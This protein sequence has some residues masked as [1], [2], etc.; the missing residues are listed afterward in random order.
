MNI[1]F[2]D[3]PETDSLQ[4]RS[5]IARLSTSISNKIISFVNSQ[6]IRKRHFL[7]LSLFGMGFNF[8]R[9]KVFVYSFLVLWATHGF[10][11]INIDTTYRISELESMLK[12]ARKSN[13]KED[14]AASYYLMAE[15]EANNFDQSGDAFKNYAN[16]REYYAILKD[17][18]MMSRIDKALGIKYL[19]SGYYQE[20]LL[21]FNKAMKYFIK[22]K[23]LKTIT[24]I[25]FHISQIY[26][27]KVDPENE[28]KY[29]NKAIQLNSKL[30][31]TT[32]LVEFM[33]HKIGSYVTLS[34]LDTAEIIAI[35]AVTLSGKFKN[36]ESMSRSLYHLG[37]INRIRK[38]YKRAIKYLNDSEE[39]VSVKPF[40]IY[41]RTLYNEMANCYQKNGNYK[42]AFRYS[43]KYSELND[44]ILNKDRIESQ[45]KFAMYYKADEKEGDNEKLK[46][47]KKSVEQKNEQQKTAMYVLT[48]G[49]IMLLALMYYIINFYRQK[50]KAE[51]II[52]GQKQEISHQKI[53]ELED[54][55]KISSMQSM[56]EGQE[57][58][59]ERISKDLHDSLGGLLS[60]IKLQFDSVKSKMNKV[61]KLKEYKSANSM[62]D[63]AVEEVRSISQNLQPGSLMKLGL[64]PALN[65]LFNR[66]DEDIYPEVDFQYYD[67]PEK[68]PTMVA[69]S[70]YRVIQ[71]LLHN[72]IKHAQ[73]SEILIQ[74]NK[75]G[76][77]L[78][79]QFE[80]DGIGYDP[81][82]LERKGMGLENI[83]SRINYLKG[84][85]S[86]NASTGEGTSTLIHVNYNGY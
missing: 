24:F 60:T 7:K 15:F 38:N 39:F 64:I 30:K 23:D 26:R 54:N 80:D 37:K 6:L 46:I 78:V 57:I 10:S 34:E 67:I 36:R 44:S 55:I 70:I 51:E 58:E 9:I 20:A 41:R 3:T 43:K 21:S 65:D 2:E 62:L 52:N 14:L 83:R 8:N 33:I 1:I 79:I 31:D 53:R 86:I 29:L 47:D 12:E 18:L 71:E 16:S 81:E 22:T 50:I 17:S 75:E 72:T 63:T 56:L 66:F 5:A 49:L 4:K 28:L 61:G 11:Q 77:E 69:L 59:R 76:D 35:D 84:Q 25:N 45:N 68:I 82:N 74:I 42:L 32:L 48:G 13:I 85:L 73:A 27:N 19:Q 40:N